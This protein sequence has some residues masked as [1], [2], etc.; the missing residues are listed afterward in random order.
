MT[1]GSGA[2]EKLLFKFNHDPTDETWAVHNCKPGG[3]VFFVVPAC[4]ELVLDGL[5][6]I[7][8]LSML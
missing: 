4:Y 3:H 1:L 8:K 6:N 7:F 2:R 5:I